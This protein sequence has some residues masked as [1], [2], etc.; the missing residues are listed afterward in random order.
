MIFFL[1][2]FNKKIAKLDV[3]TLTGSAFGCV[4]RYFNELN[5][6][7]AAQPAVK[8]EE[9]PPLAGLDYI[10]SIALEVDTTI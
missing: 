2:L 3:R 1:Q 5:F 8:R 10:W 6:P 7:N 4:E 9:C